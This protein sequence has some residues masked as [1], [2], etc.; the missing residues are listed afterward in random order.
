[1]NKC[2]ICRVYVECYNKPKAC[3]WDHNGDKAICPLSDEYIDTSLYDKQIR[4]DAI[5]EFLNNVSE[6]II[7]DVLA[8]IM[9]RNI[10]A[11]DGAD[12]IIDYCRKLQKG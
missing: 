7:W 9:K 8:E 3:A 12:K 2:K 5:N 10:G 6:S 4:A 1:M 11:S